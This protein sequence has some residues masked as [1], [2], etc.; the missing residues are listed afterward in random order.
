METKKAF[1]HGYDI[2]LDAIDS[3]ADMT[4]MTEILVGTMCL[5]TAISVIMFVFLFVL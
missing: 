2:G 5:G 3:L 1:S 4:A